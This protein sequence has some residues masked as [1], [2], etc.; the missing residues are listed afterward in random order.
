MRPLRF[1]FLASVLLPALAFAA[2][3]TPGDG[4]TSKKDDRAPAPGAAATDPALASKRFTIAPGL[5]CDLWAAEPLIQ[6]VVAFSF[7][8]HG[9]AY[10]VETGRRRTSVPDIRKHMDW[11]LPSLAFRTV[12]D[13]A[14]FMRKAY[15]SDAPLK[16][17]SQHEDF[18]G[19][20]H[21]DWQDLAIESERIRLVED[22]AGAGVADTSV[23]FAEGFN[24]V[25]TGVAAGVLASGGHV[26]FACIPNLWKF[27]ASPVWSQPAASGT[28]IAAGFGVHI[29][30]GG[31][32]MHGVKMGPD[33]RLYW[34]IADCGARVTT[35]GGKTIEAQDYGAVFRSEPDGT[36]LELYAKGLRNPESLAFNDVGDLFTGDNNADGGDKARWEH[37]VEGADYGWRIGWQFLPKLGA[38]NSELLWEMNAGET[39]YSQLPPVA[40]IG[41]GPSGIA[42][43]PGTGL[44]ERF[45]NTFFYADF[46]GGVRSFTLERKGASYIATS[47]TEV[48]LNNK[49]SEMTNKLLWGLYPTDV[50]FGVDGGAYVLDWVEGWEKTGKGR[51]FRVHDPAV[52]ATP[53][54]ILTKEILAQG[55]TTRSDAELVELLGHADQRVRLGAQFALVAKGEPAT[56]PLAAAAAPGSPLLKRLHAIWGLGQ[57]GRKVAKPAVTLKALLTDEEPEVRAQAAHMLG[58][59]STQ[60]AAKDVALAAKLDVKKLTQEST[61]YPLTWG[62]R[63]LLQDPEPR[64]RF[65][66]AQ[67]IGKLQA[68]EAVPALLALAET[69]ADKDPYIRHAVSLALTTCADVP[70]LSAETKNKSDAVRAVVLLALRRL[71]C[72][73]VGVFLHDPKPQLVLEAARAIHDEPI[74]SA[75]PELA[76]TSVAGQPAPV[77]RRIVN[78]GYRLGTSAAAE[79]LGRIAQETA[80]AAPARLDALEALTQWNEPLGRDRVLGTWRA[81]LPGH[82]AAAAQ[83]VAATLAPRLLHDA[84][85][86]VQL[87]ALALIAG[88]KATEAEAA[89][90]AVLRDPKADGAVRAETLRVLSVTK[91]PKLPEAIEFAR[92]SNVPLLTA[93]ARRLSG[94]LSPAEAVTQALAA[95]DTGEMADRQAAFQSLATLKDPSSRR[96]SASGSTAWCRAKCRPRCNSMCWKPPPRA[97]TTR[98]R[99]N[100]PITKRARKPTTRWRASANAWRVAMP[101]PAG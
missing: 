55:F 98:S 47:P 65:F 58:E 17:D 59:C 94:N 31:H 62:L 28:A 73:E 13:R 101:R 87:A 37:I 32:D 74:E 97:R 81:A 33:G 61:A 49:Q 2:E 16:P 25:E 8:E 78:A 63:N 14:A 12:A 3:P 11:L 27:T 44:P 60:P 15:P 1:L 90:L 18:N 68:A 45:A 80:G 42:Y 75:L 69:N 77:A 71:G 5:Q 84:A 51:I 70:A 57:L 22:R 36:K 50:Q 21:Y 30:Y 83:K 89:L 48:L 20:G 10:V 56:T 91:A 7:D 38:W 86:E 46:P 82:D 88:S 93:A 6:N 67:A 66:A 54:V 4:T 72:A 52:D 53:E 23:V 99:R 79:T 92:A 85:K 29:A 26:Y 24:F 76:A 39:A 41:H 64:V 19:D 35:E 95:L 43:Y 34:S 100:S 96:R 9:R 40:H